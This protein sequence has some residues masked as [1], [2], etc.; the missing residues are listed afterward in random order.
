MATRFAFGPFLLDSARGTLTREGAAVAVGQRGL[1]LLHALLE[2]G[3]QP[4]T[5]AELLLRA[6]P[7]LVVED[8][9]LSVQI[10]ALRRLLDVP[11]VAGAPRIVSVPRLGYRLDGVVAVESSDLSPL[12]HGVPD[13]SGRP[14]IA[15]LP[16]EPLGEDD[17]QD[18]EA[19]GVT[20]ALITALTRFRWFTVVGRNASQVFK[21]RP[22]GAG[23]AAEL[24]VRHVV[25]GTVRRAGTRVRIHVRLVD[26]PSGACVWAQQFDGHDAGLFELQDRMAQDVAGAIEPEL[27]KASGRPSVVHRPGGVTAWEL[28]AHGSWLFHH[29]TGP[30]HRQAREMFRQA[31]RVAAGLPEAHLWLGRVNAGLVAYGWSEDAG[32]DLAEGLAGAHAAVRLDERNPYAHYALAIVSN[33]AH[34]ATL[35]L[36]CAEKAIE[37][38][39]SFA[40]GHLV[41]GMAALFAGDAARASSALEQGL[42]LNRYDPQNFVW[43]TMHAMALLFDGPADG[44]Q[45]GAALDRAVAALK[46]R[47][48][49]QPAM[50]AAAAACALM[51][52]RAAA[53][54]W[55]RRAS[56]TPVDTS[57]A[58][59]PMWQ[60][61]PLWGRRM[62][63]W[64][65][66]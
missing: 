34:D 5:K 55:L 7:G 58:M 49:W 41:H 61:C 25:E 38:N 23:A 43:Y 20:E 64:L 65:G 17:A 6:W 60:R 8:S 42:R 24:G 35:A 37:L 27:L 30:T 18:H 2:A 10:S 11:G 51:G 48:T 33:Y 12:D 13:P 50:K 59:Q 21:L 47:P 15:V 19:D 9:N 14:S 1:R 16:F 62:G 54:D 32:A 26:V 46:I 31:S 52:E 56:S 28:V 36:R 53:A 44:G 39:P 45:A 63:Q 4:V 3:G 29:V 66:W 57:D 22:G 40:L